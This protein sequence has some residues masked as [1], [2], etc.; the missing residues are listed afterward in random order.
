MKIALITIHRVTNYGA[1]LQAYATKA[2]LSKYGEVKT[3][4]YSNP[5]LDK[6]MVKLRFNFSVHGVKMLIHDLLNLPNRIKLLAKF[7]TF[8][9]TKFNLTPKLNKTELKTNKLEQFDVYVCGSD[10]I[11][12]PKVVSDRGIIDKAYFLNFA[13]P[14]SVK[15]SY[16][17]S[18][19][20][21]NFTLEEKKEV[22]S[23]LSDFDH[24][25]VRESDGVTKI[26]DILPQKAIHHVVDPTLL[27]NK[28]DWLKEFNIIEEVGQEYILVYS[29]PRTELLRS[30]IDYFSKKL[31]LRVVAIDKMFFSMEHI[32]EH[33]NTAGPK[34]FLQLYANA[35]FVITDSFHGTCFA[36]NFHKPFVAISANERA[37]RQI[38]LLKLLDIEDRLMFKKEDFH[39]L[40]LELEYKSGLSTKL[41][42]IREKSLQYIE[43]SIR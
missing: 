30:A 17:S 10:Q 7:N 25:S 37:N 28:K 19:G 38:S 27:L 31:K 20:H 40:D 36:L 32:N 22:K 29:V 35:S 33:I 14:K 21:H 11:W 42:A 15:F 6:H 24:I 26:K 39:K 3:I 9:D 41:N 13:K 4:D 2:I 12:N 5:F 43:D 16:A 34:D 8:I 23:L 18:I 1:L